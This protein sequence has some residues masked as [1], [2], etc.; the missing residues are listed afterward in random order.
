MWVLD[1]QG[2]DDCK[3]E[4]LILSADLNY[5]AGSC[6]LS[7]TKH[8]LLPE[9]DSFSFSNNPQH[10]EAFMSTEP[11]LPQATEEHYP[12]LRCIIHGFDAP[13]TCRFC[14]PESIPDGFLK[15]LQPAPTKCFLVPDSHHVYP[16][17]APWL[18]LEC[19]HS[20]KPSKRNWCV[21]NTGTLSSCSTCGKPKKPDIMITHGFCVKPL[22]REGKPRRKYACCTVN[23]LKDGVC[24]NEKCKNKL[25]PHWGHMKHPDRFMIP[26]TVLLM[27]QQ[28]GMS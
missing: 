4:R 6:M 14:A 22:L 20:V 16:E 9:T 24:I 12:G 11:E 5:H 10:L 2:Y 8:L 15:V 3:P 17:S 7:S 26:E 18:C 23:P 19:L 25:T 27:T 21:M 13:P 28:D 1:F